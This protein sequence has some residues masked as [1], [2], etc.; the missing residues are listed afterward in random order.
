MSQTRGI[1]MIR[2]TIAGVLK[3]VPF[4]VIVLAAFPHVHAGKPK[5]GSKWLDREVVV[6]GINQEWEG[7][8]TPIKKT[9]ISIG[10]FNDA[11]HLYLGVLSTEP[12]EQMQILMRGLTVWFDPKGGTKKRYGVRFPLG[13]RD[14]GIQMN[15]PGSGRD[16]ESRR[17]LA[18]EMLAEMDRFDIIGPKKKETR[19]VLFADAPP[20]EV[21]AGLTEDTLF[22]E[23]RI[24]LARAEEDF[25]GIGIRRDKPIGVGL[26]T[27]KMEF[28]GR[29]PGG[30]GGRRPGG[31]GG[32]MPGGG[33]GGM[34][35]GMPGGMGGG[36]PGGGPGG[37]GGGMPGGGRGGMGGGW[38][39]PTG[40]GRPEMPKPVKVWV[41]VEVDRGDVLQ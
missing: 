7:V 4:L 29:R 16:P 2:K 23:L 26:E 5:L 13:L 37:M 27:P 39:G 17:E 25:Y 41:K 22:Y 35:G 40:G 15:D 8:M 11:D 14:S 10:V 24:P 6:D 32:G 36:M 3:T 18:R 21:R 28:A 12:R 19:R 31:M 34:G 9:G 20:I 38:P 30:M 33:R 1:K